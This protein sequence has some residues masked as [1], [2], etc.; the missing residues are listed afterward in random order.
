MITIQ[1]QFWKL[2]ARLLIPVILLVILCS[3]PF[4]VNEYITSILVQ[5]LLYMALGQMWNLL[6][7]YAGLVSLGQQMFVGLGGYSLAVI[8]EIY[9]LPIILGIITGGVVSVI[10][11]VIIS[12][13]IFKM[14]GVYF[15][16][17][18]WIAAEALA[19][20][21]SNW[22]YVRSGQGFN[23]TASYE[24]TTVDLYYIALV[25]GA[26]AVVLVYAL[27]RSTLGLALMAMRD[28]ESAAE[29][30][31]I[32]LYQTKLKCF[33]LAAFVTGITGAA[34]YL[35]IAYVQPFAAFGIDWTV[36]MVFMVIIGGTG[37]IEG[38]VLGAV[39]YVILKQYLYDY[40]GIS[41]IILGIIAIGVIFVAPKGAMGTLYERYGFEILSARRWTKDSQR[42]KRD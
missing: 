20:Y 9:Q 13:P 15:S 37:T 30:V 39:L 4:L 11:A 1:S 25:V 34:L 40:P 19:V 29:T 31:G 6:A 38:P 21:F 26:G 14:R 27:L 2:K 17:G 23:I 7:G 8:T 22:T 36:A 3:L 28:N 42:K 12:Q 18:T 41:M 10:L 33:L 5:I 24:L 32:E 35:S 16:I